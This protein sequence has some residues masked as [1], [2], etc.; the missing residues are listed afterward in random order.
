MIPTIDILKRAKEVS[1]FAPLSTEEKN[2]AILKMADSLIEN[3]EEILSANATDVENAL[4]G[5]VYDYQ[6]I[7]QCLSGMEIKQYFD[8]VETEE[9]VKLMI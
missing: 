8:G 6:S 7:H 1:R 9:L 3:K 5:V 4:Q 2:N